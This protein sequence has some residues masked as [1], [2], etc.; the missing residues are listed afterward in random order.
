[1][2]AR[3][4]SRLRA[5]AY[6]GRTVTLKLRRYDFTTLT[7][8]QTLPHPTDDPRVIAS[9]AARL[10]AEAG[11]QG[12][13]RLLGV[14]VSGLSLYAQGDLFAIDEEPVDDAVEASGAE[15]EEAPE[16]LTAEARWWPGQ[17]V[18]HDEHGA[19]W[20]W[21]RGLGRVTVRFEGPLTPPGP[22]RTLAADDPALHPAEPP[23]WRVSEPAPST[24]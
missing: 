23:E 18:R 6:S 10:L 7:R 19:G 1:M 14:G 4:G 2:A 12:G 17:D 8:S 16:P 24:P 20:V 13:L 22:V 3:V 11:T 9:I 5:S 15:V 21:G